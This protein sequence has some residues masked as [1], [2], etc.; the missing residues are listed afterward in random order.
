M[1]Q[2]FA[3]LNADRQ[4]KVLDAAAKIFALDG[5][6]PASITQIC[7][8]AKISNGALYKYFKNKEDLFFAVLDRCV[9]LM[10][11]EI[12][13]IYSSNHNTGLAIRMLLQA[14][15]KLADNYRDYL[16]IYA[17]LGSSSHTVFAAETSEK[18]ELTVSKYLRRVVED[19][20]RRNEFNTQLDDNLLTF[21][22]DNYVMLFLYSLV[23]EYHH[24]RFESFF[25][26]GKGVLSTKEKIDLVMQSISIIIK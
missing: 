26:E 19:G 4:A 21:F 10:V 6:H 18:F 23:S 1:L 20:K 7:E 25:C 17:D 14:T 2:A 8:E 12:V 22:I 5:Y 15:E 24:N 16:T 11:N 9:N 3:K 13:T